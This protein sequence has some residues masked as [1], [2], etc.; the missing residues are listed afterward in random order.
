MNRRIFLLGCGASA[1]MTRLRGTGVHI[2]RIT[3]ANTEGRFHK[4]V[5]M[6]SHD[7]APKGHTYV[8]TVVRVRT[9]SGIEGAGV[10]GYPLPDAA[11]V[12]ALKTLIG[13]DP[14]DLYRMESGRIVDRNPRYA[15][16]LQRYRFLDGPLFDLIGKLTGK[17]AWQL[18]GDSARD[19][20][21]VYDGTLYFSDIWF[22][23]LGVRAVVDEAR[24][25]VNSGY[26]AIKLKLGRGYQWMEKEAGLRRDIEVVHAVREAVGPSVR[27]MVDPNTG[28]DADRDRAWRLMSETA[29]AKLYWME[30]I[31]SATVEDYTW[32]KNKMEAAGIA[33]LIADGEGYDG[34]PDFAPFLKP[35]RLMDVLQPDIRRCGFIDELSV[36]RAAEPVGAAV[37]PHNW[38]S[39]TGF[40]MTLQIAKAVKNIP[41][42]E[43]DRST[44]DVFIPEGYEFR[45]G[46]YSVPDNPGLSHR[47][48]ESVYALK[49]QPKE[50]VVA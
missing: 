48:D 6:N 45:N 32:L 24:E 29:S 19:R 44:C 4:F 12:D 43:D 1:A 41:G 14:L 33:T 28:Y 9:N 18:L 47:V 15:Q 3:L 26:H 35:R 25:A 38:G 11:L 46:S 42:A 40:L 34:V 31:F 7:K 39:H 30:Q 49:C 10:M 2:N 27:I 13:A 36:N 22:P 50:I 37:M 21:D 23:D 17:A 16:V 8:N 5:T 20:I